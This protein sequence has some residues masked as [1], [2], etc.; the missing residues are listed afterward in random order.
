MVLFEVGIG[1]CISLSVLSL[2]S[3][4][5]LNNKTLSSQIAVFFLSPFK[6]LLAPY[7]NWLVRL[8]TSPA[9]RRKAVQALVAYIAFGLLVCIAMVAY[10]VFYW[11]YIPQLHHVGHILLQYT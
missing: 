6:N 4:Y 5:L 9:T 11:V 1:Y 8:V 3:F 7:V 10:L 2:D